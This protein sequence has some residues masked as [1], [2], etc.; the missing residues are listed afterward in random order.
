MRLLAIETATQ[1]LSVAVVEDENLLAAAQLLLPT[2]PHAVE[3]PGLVQRLLL[4]TRTPWKHLGAVAID[5]GPGS[6]TGLRIGLAFVKAIA[7]AHALRVVG[8]S[9]LDV[10]AAQAAYADDPVVPLLDA[11]RGNVYG[12]RF[13]RKGDGFVRRTEYRLGSVEEALAGVPRRA[14]FLGEA[15]RLYADRI[16]AVCPDTSFAP[17]EL[18]W[19]RAETLARLGVARLAAGRAD[20]PATLVPLYLYPLDCSVRS[21]PKPVAG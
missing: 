18:W 14:L 10:L 2:H 1:N 3:L 13:D 17:Q 7:F 12:A 8:V 16:R 5:I 11:K 6:F 21:E 19:P 9:S 20:D 4:T 15:C